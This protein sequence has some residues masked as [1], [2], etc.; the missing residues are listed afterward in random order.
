[1]SLDSVECICNPNSLASMGFQSI[2]SVTQK[3]QLALDATQDRDLPA[4]ANNT[5]STIKLSTKASGT[6]CLYN[7]PTTNPDLQVFNTKTNSEGYALDPK[8]YSKHNWRYPGLPAGCLVIEVKDSNGITKNI[9]GGANHV[10]D[11]QPGYSA[12][13]IVN[14]D[15]KWYANNEGKII[16][17][18]SVASSGPAPNNLPRPIADLFNTGVD[19]NRKPLGDSAPDPHYEMSMYPAVG[20]ALPAVTTPNSVLPTINWVPNSQTSRWI[21]PNASSST[22]PVGS[23]AYRTYFTLPE[24]VT[25][26]ISGQLCADDRI[27][28]IRVN[29]ISAAIPVPLSSWTTVARFAITSGFRPGKNYIEFYLNNVG[30]PTGLNID[31]LAGIYVPLGQTPA[32]MPVINYISTSAA[33]NPPAGLKVTCL[34]SP[35]DLRSNAQHPVISYKG[36]DFWAFSYIDNRVSFGLCGIKNGQVVKSI[37][38]PGNRYVYAITVN[39]ANKTVTICGQYGNTDVPWSSL[40]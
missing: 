13:F 27:V 4:L 32:E 34:I 23:Y 28:D 6:W 36:V 17:D 21:G 14:D 22:G 15:P 39:P 37:E 10:I 25:A 33:P 29:G 3:G 18:Y 1:M 2:T 11:L 9:Y 16:L 40:A 26:S 7:T 38:L 8:V 30:G 19:D 5:G 12:A 20:T 31:G 35:S 24:F